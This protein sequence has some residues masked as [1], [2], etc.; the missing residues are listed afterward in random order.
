[1]DEF[2]FVGFL[3][4]KGAKRTKKI[5]E[6]VDQERT[7]VLYESSHRMNKLLDELLE[8]CGDRFII[9]C[10]ELTK[11]FEEVRRSPLSEHIT[12]FKQ[13]APRGEFVV[14]IPKVKA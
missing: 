9:V 14:V 3:P 7:V 8:I 10:R 5:Q 6:A 13:Q 12:H 4:P 1:M 2:T 11:K